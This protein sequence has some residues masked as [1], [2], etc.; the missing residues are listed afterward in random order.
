M[1]PVFV[2]DLP[3]IAGTE[4]A[5]LSRQRVLCP[6][7]GCELAVMLTGA[8]AV[9]S[10]VVRNNLQKHIERQHSDRGVE[11]VTQAAVNSGRSVAYARPAPQVPRA[12]NYKCYHCGAAPGP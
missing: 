8:D 1:D 10:G 2:N 11:C 9:N 7:L 5:Y 6:L 4:G 12:S 3:A